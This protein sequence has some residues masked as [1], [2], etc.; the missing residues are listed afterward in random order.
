MNVKWHEQHV[1]PERATL[2]QRI[3]WHGEHQL[4]CACRPIPAKLQA[5]ML[6]KPRRKRVT[7]APSLK[8]KAKRAKKVRAR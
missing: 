2:E 8:K 4:A 1:M 5:L 7:K 3:A 6:D